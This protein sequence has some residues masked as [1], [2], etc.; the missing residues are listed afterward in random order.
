MNKYTEKNIQGELLAHILGQLHHQMAVPNNAGVFRWEC[1]VLSVT[2]SGMFMEWEI[3]ISRND[4][5]ADFKK[6]KHK[7]FEKRSEYYR[8]PS[9]LYYVVPETL[10]ISPEEV[11]K[12]AGLIYLNEKIW[13]IFRIIKRAPRLHTRKMTD[14]QKKKLVTSLNWK[15]AKYLKEAHPLEE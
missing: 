9:Y 3:K 10:E 14:Y 2:K 6:R 13:D 8:T 11:P 5:A 12:Y 1:D 4:F 15:T 7:F